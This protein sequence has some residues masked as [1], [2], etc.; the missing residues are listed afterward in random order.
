MDI[1]WKK[2]DLWRPA[3]KG[4]LRSLEPTRIDRLPS[5]S[6]LVIYSNHMP[7]SDRFIDKRRLFNALAEG[8]SLEFNGSGADKTTTMPVLECTNSVTTDR[9]T[10]RQTDRTG[11]TISRSA[12]IAL[13]TRYNWQER[14]PINLLKKRKCF[15]TR[16]CPK[17]TLHS[18]LLSVSMCLINRCV[19][20]AET[21][22]RRLGVFPVTCCCRFASGFCCQRVTSRVAAVVVSD[23]QGGNAVES[24]C[25]R[26]CLSRP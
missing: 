6:Y 23:K 1:R 21:R 15:E 9:Q 20:S 2:N 11:R 4:H 5:T 18:N 7:I 22:P 25:V 17:R 26:A 12:C 19:Q 10:D 14:H 13:L 3:F 24:V 8:L 16:W